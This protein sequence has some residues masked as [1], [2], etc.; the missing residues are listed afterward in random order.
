MITPPFPDAVRPQVAGSHWNRRF[1]VAGAIAFT[2]AAS[3]V[4]L[5]QVAED[6]SALRIDSRVI[7]LTLPLFVV[8]TAIVLTTLSLRCWRTVWEVLAIVAAGGIL[9]VPSVLAALAPSFKLSSWFFVIALLFWIV[10]AV[11]FVTDASYGR[12]MQFLLWLGAASAITELVCEF[13]LRG[14]IPFA[15]AAV[16]QARALSLLLDVRITLS[17]SFAALCLATAVLR[18][19]ALAPPNTWRIPTKALAQVSEARRVLAPLMNPPILVLNGI[20]FA[21]IA[22]LNVVIGVFLTLLLRILFTGTE[23]GKLIWE[24]LFE[25]G[26]ALRLLKGLVS[27]IVVL[28]IIVAALETAPALRDYLRSSP[29]SVAG[30]LPVVALAGVVLVGSTLVALVV[31]G[32]QMVLGRVLFGASLLVVLLVMSG[33]LVYATAASGLL[34]VSGFADIGLISLVVGLLVAVGAL[35]VILMKLRGKREAEV[36]S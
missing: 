20:L 6:V 1:S 9:T 17:L 31:D 24:L 13:G 3:L 18:E 34:R 2:V 19:F 7:D 32:R 30:L 11:W 23:F 35:A 12:W 4:T 33:G 8:F 36:A 5:G 22:L 21:I 26:A 16:T 10:V 27:A 28:S 15:R 25:G 29:A 14:P